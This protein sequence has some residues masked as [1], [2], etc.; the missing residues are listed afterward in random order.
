M[1]GPLNGIRIVDLTRVLAGPSATQMLGDLGADVIKI[2]RPESGDDTRK[3]GPPFLKDKEGNPTSESAYYLSTNRSKRSVALDISDKND[4]NTLKKL[5][6]KADVLIENFKVGGLEKYGLDYARLRSDHP[7]LI[8]ASLTGFGQTGPY[9]DVPG[10]DFMI[11]GMGGI[12]SST[13]PVEGPPF[14]VGVAIADIMAGQYLL[15]GILAALYHREKTGQGQHVDVALFDSQ[16]AWLANLGQYYLTSGENPPRVGNAH[17]TI[18]PYEV[19]ETADSHIIL[20]VG[21]DTQF[22]AFCQVAGQGDLAKDPDY[23]SNP[24]RVKNREILVPVIQDILKTRSTNDWLSALKTAKVPSGPVNTI[25]QAFDHPQT[26]AR[27]MVVKMSHVDGP[28]S[29]IGNPVKL[30]ETPVCYDKAPPKCGADT[31]DVLREWLNKD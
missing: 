11:Q 25:S 5:I 21:N 23:A 22:A 8:Y 6:A 3:W 2:E 26:A 28:V 29:L 13:G 10:Y 20:A 12:M 31:Q 17:T 9:K 14:K 16:L 18:V 19:F 15:N 1:S 4:L 30:S 7:G 27:D 24:A